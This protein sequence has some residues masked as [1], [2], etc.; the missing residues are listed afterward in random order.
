MNSEHDTKETVMLDLFASLFN[1][2]SLTG[3]L[4][5]SS[6]LSTDIMSLT[7]HTRSVD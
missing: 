3:L 7:G 2:S 4:F 6:S 5:L 1:I